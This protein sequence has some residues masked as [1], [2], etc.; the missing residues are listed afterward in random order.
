MS[1][2]NST[3]EMEFDGEQFK[4]SD[5]D[6]Y[7]KDYSDESFASKIK[8]AVKKAGAGLIYKALQLF[9]VTQNPNCPMKIKAGIF[10]A[11][12]YFITPLDVIPDF[13]PIVGYTDDAAAIAIA[14]T[15]AHIY[16]DDDVKRK[17]Q[18]KLVSLFGKK[19]LSDNGII[20]YKAD[21]K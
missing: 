11:L 10:A 2:K 14:I 17:A 20:A 19:I 15:L 16:I 3:V 13:A 6:K 8:S 21:L 4:Q 9:Y 18:E 12:G 7:A 5:M 1:E